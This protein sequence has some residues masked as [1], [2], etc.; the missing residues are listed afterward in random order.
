M[1]LSVGAAARS[2][3]SRA[4]QHEE[5]PQCDGSSAGNDTLR[6]VGVGVGVDPLSL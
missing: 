1:E 5:P 6:G 3:A 2:P 4:A